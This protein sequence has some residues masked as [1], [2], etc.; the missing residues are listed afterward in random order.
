M[1]ENLEKHIPKHQEESSLVAS[2]V[3]SA[4]AGDRASFEELITIYQEKIFSMVYYRT[5]SHM[6]SEDLT[7]DIFMKAFRSLHTL[8][9]KT[10]FRSWLYSIA[11]NRVRD[12]HKKKR[13]LVF[14]DREGEMKDSDT[15]NMEIHDEPQEVDHLMRQ[16]FWG[17]V[18]NFTDKLSRWEREVFLLRFLDQLTIREMAQALSKSESA[19]KTHLYRAIKKFKE[20]NE[21]TQLLIGDIQ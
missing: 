13:F 3:E 6:D 15:S 17:H 8:K 18:R 10:R 9:D 7:Q 2:A 5:G 11:V 4:L 19:I 16:E 1:T 12:F 20:N 14:F 21:L